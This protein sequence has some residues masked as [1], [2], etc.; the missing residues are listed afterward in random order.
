MR[1]FVKI[2]NAYYVSVPR[3]LV[4]KYN[5]QDYLLDIE[6]REDE[7]VIRKIRGVRL[8]RSG[9]MHLEKMRVNVGEN[10]ESKE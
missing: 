6:V 3:K 8:I 7:I 9:V 10:D 2:G 4:E 1:S 5:W